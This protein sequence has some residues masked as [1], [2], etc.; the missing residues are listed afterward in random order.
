MATLTTVPVR[1]A[2]N[3][4]RALATGAL[5][6]ALLAGAFGAA[7]Q[8]AS[9]VDTFAATGS[10]AQG[11]YWPAWSV[12]PDGKVLVA[13]GSGN[14]PGSPS[15]SSA[16]IYDPA[17]GT[18]SATAPMSTTR[19]RAGFVTLPDGKV[20]VA[21]GETGFGT[22]VMSSAELYDPATG[23]WSATAPMSTPRVDFGMVL[24]AN[25]KVLAGGGSSGGGGSGLSSAELYDPATGTWSATGSLTAIAPNTSRFAPTLQ[26][27]PWVSGVADPMLPVMYPMST[28]A[29]TWA[30][31]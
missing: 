13:G 12:L 25:G 7:A 22:G 20:L 14:S 19:R 16:E 11:R 2:N 1:P 28:D 10:M 17:A 30:R 4:R 24:L 9:A 5:T 21:G 29:G 8:S 15:L 6:F 23:T 18:W 26:I 3:A 31:F 27:T